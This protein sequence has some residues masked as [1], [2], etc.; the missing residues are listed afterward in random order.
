MTPRRGDVL[1]LHGTEYARL[2]PAPAITVTVDAVGGAVPRA[3]GRWVR[4]RVRERVG[5]LDRTGFVEVRADAVAVAA[6]R[7]AT[8]VARP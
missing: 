5:G 4:L 3:D 2:D 1:R 7:A 6:R 8:G